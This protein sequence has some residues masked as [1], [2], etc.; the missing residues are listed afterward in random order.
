MGVDAPRTGGVTVRDGLPNPL[1]GP[2]PPTT[3]CSGGG[4]LK[5]GQGLPEV[6]V[7]WGS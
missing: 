2:V 6:C 1:L 3:V 7:R 4:N 5:D